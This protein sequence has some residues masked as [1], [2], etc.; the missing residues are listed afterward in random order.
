MFIFQVQILL[1]QSF[2]PIFKNALLNNKFLFLFAEIFD[3]L[4]G[5]PER[6]FCCSVL[7]Q[8]FIRL[9]VFRS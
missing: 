1:F 8:I 7:L 9:P 6:L 2:K 4:Y 3:F 5:F